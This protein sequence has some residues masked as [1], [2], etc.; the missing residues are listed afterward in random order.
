MRQ[1]DLQSMPR[2]A[3]SY[4]TPPVVRAA[5]A[6]M[7]RLAD[8]SP[9]R[10]GLATTDNARFVRFWWEVEP[11]SAAP[12]AGATPGRWFPYAKG[13]RFRRWYEA[14]RHRVNWE[15]DGRQIKQSI[16]ERY[17]YLNGKWEWVA[18]NA[19]CYGR[20]GGVCWSY[21]TSGC[22]SARRLEAGSI[23]DVAASSVFPEDPLGLLALLNSNAAAQLPAAINPTVNFQVGD[24]GELPFPKTLPRELGELAARGIEL[25]RTGNCNRG[26]SRGR[27]RG[28]DPDNGFAACGFANEGTRPRE[29]LWKS[30]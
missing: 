17:P 3:W 30:R 20:P 14:P 2:G 23:F 9:P 11:I 6:R 7:P 4:W 1:S 25:Q 15:D 12:A 21:L 22:F 24:L 26:D 5:F 16:V 10:Q 27:N 18:K 8:L 28:T 13:G 19:S 29:N